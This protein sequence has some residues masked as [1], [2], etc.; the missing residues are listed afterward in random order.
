MRLTI[1]G[2]SGSVPCPDKP[3]SGYLLEASG[4]RLLMDLGN[5]TLAELQRHADP[6]EVDAMLLS[7]LHADHCA[8]VT[9]LTVLRRFHPSVLGGRALPRLPLHGPSESATRLARA[10]APDSVELAETDLADVFDFRPLSGEAFRLGPFEVLP[11]PVVHP[12]EA[13]GFRI[14]AGGRTLA[15]T[16]DTAV[17]DE[18]DRLADG[19][20]VLLAEASW[21]HDPTRPAGM[22]LSGVE[23]GALAARTGAGKLLLTH[24]LPWTDGDAVLA[25]ARTTFTGDAR[26]VEV[27][28][29]YEI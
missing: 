9:A 25:E 20:D 18:L 13:Y 5:G 14:T 15:F 12:C 8:D 16:G 23:A 24:V 29:E 27:G 7:H 19:V 1:L 6:L 21:T 17:T 22:H 3:A 28:D 11:V 2:C 4:F 10:Y 26:L